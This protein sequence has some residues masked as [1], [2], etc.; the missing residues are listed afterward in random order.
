MQILDEKL[1]VEEVA[2][3]WLK[4]C[5]KHLKLGLLVQPQDNFNKKILFSHSV[6]V[7]I[8]EIVHPN[9]FITY[10]PTC[11]FKPV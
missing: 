3:R 5:D 9:S 10:S 1:L 4:M 8:K 2:A 11:H 7:K 6:D